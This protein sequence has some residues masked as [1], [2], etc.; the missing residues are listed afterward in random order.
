VLN[1]PTLAMVDGREMHGRT[2]YELSIVKTNTR[3]GS[4]S[5]YIL[6]SGSNFTCIVLDCIILATYSF[7]NFL[8]QLF[9][10]LAHLILHLLHFILEKLGLLS[11]QLFCNLLGH[12]FGIGLLLFGVRHCFFSRGEVLK[13]DL[14]L[15]SI[16]RI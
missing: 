16:E 12:F 7:F 2:F 6:I 15:I 13:E 4:L 3:V 5:M 11:H 8:A 14:A 10:H 9:I 1:I